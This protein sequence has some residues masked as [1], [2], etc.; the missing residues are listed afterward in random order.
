MIFGVD[1]KDYKE[2]Y[3]AILV[4]LH[5]KKEEGHN[6]GNMRDVLYNDILFDVGLTGIRFYAY[7]SSPF[8]CVKTISVRIDILANA[9]NLFNIFRPVI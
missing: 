5:Y 6:Q 4:E 1:I 7:R 2:K 3:K 8:L 9:R